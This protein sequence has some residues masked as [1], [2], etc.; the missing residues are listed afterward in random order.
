M[1]ASLTRFGY[2]VVFLVAVA[3]AFFAFPQGM[4]SWREKQRQ[5]QEMEKRNDGL[6][7]AVERQKD[8]INRLKNNPAV[9]ELEIRR[10]LKLLHPEEQMYIMGEPEAPAQP[11][12]AR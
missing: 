10:R 8:Y 9:Q 7:K 6:A 2:I 11:P 1:K 4:H 3:Y 5:I 12:A